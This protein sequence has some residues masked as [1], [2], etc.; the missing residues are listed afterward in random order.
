MNLISE[1]HHSCERKE[2]A[3]IVLR[4]YTIISLSLDGIIYN[5]TYKYNHNEY[6]YSNNYHNYYISIFYIF[7]KIILCYFPIHCKGK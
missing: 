1:T 7:L 2:Y 3:F 4:E 5:S 6:T